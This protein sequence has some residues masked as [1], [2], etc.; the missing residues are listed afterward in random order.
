MPAQDVIVLA[1]NRLPGKLGALLQS[2]T[3]KRSAA[4][5][6][7]TASALAAAPDPLC[8]CHE[9]SDAGDLIVTIAFLE[10]VCAAERDTRPAYGGLS[11]SEVPIGIGQLKLVRAGVV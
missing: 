2:P 1:G 4:W 7:T 6:A 9:R 3:S 11:R 5:R 10:S 8:L